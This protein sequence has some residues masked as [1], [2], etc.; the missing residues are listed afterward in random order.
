LNGTHQ[1]VQVCI[2]DDNSLVENKCSVKKYTEVV[3]VANK[4]A[5]LDVSSE[6]KIVFSYV[7]VSSTESRT[8]S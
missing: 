7:R 8:K 1:L 4:E 5:G 2:D 6:K 3:L